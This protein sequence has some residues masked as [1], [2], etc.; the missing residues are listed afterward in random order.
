MDNDKEKVFLEDINRN[1]DKNSN[2][3]EENDSDSDDGMII[4]NE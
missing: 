4:Q 2:Y 3:P 1:I